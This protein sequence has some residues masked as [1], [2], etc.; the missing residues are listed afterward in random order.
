MTLNHMPV[1][2]AIGAKCSLQIHS[3]SRL[4][5]AKCRSLERLLYDIKLHFRIAEFNHAETYARER[6]AGTDMDVAE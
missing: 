6:D 5:E 3:F 4:K 2:P 1:K